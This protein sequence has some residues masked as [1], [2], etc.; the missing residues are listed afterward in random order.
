MIDNKNER[1]K[2][3]VEIS[4]ILEIISKEIY[5][6]SFALLREN[7]QNAYDAILMRKQKNGDD[8]DVGNGLIKIEISNNTI[9]VEDNGIGMTEDTL[10]EN[11]WKAGSSGKNTEFALSAGVIGTFGIGAMANFGVCRKLIVET[12][13]I[14][15]SITLYSEL[16]KGNISLSEDCILLNRTE[17]DRNPG[18]KITVELEPEYVISVEQAKSYIEQYVKYIPVMVMLNGSNMSQTDYRKLIFSDVEKLIPL[19]N[20]VINSGFYSADLNAMT[21]KSGDVIFEMTNIRFGNVMIQGEIVLKQGKEYVMGLRNY[22]GLAPIPVNQSY[23]LGGI[24]NLY[25]LQPTAGRE[26]LSRDSIE[27]VN[28][29]LQL[30]EEQITLMLS[31]TEYADKNAM[32]INY[33]YNKGKSDLAANVRVEVKPD[34]IEIRMKDIINNFAKFKIY[35]YIGRDNS[36][37]N[38]FSSE[39]KKLLLLSGTTS[40]QRIQVDYLRKLGVEEVPDQIRVLKIYDMKELATD[41]FSFLFRLKK[42]LEEDYFLKDIDILM[43]DIS[44]HIPYKI[45]NIKEKLTI[46]ISRNSQTIMPLLN[47][48]YTDF[49][50]FSSLIKD[51]VRI[52]LYPYILPFVPSSSKQGLDV[53]RKILLSKKE[54]FEIKY[55]EQGRLELEFQLEKYRNGEM[56]LE[57]VIESAKL[58]ST[59]HRQDVNSNQI[60]KLESEIPDIVENQLLQNMTEDINNQNRHIA[61]NAEYIPL[62]AISRD[63]IETNMKVLTL[64]N[65]FAQLNNFKMFLSLTEKV[66]DS[67]L[68]F[69]LQP[70]TTKI[71]WG[72]HRII[73]I[74]GHV[75]GKIT[76]YYD[77]DLDSSISNSATGGSAFQTTTI[78]TKNKIFVPVPE[79]LIPIFKV[80]QGSKRFFIR[81]DEVIE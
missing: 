47:C 48:Y 22:F 66:Y 19:G 27:H 41:E 79:P 46:Y 62:S 24:V 78:L 42:V 21:D 26:A 4:K 76:L 52:H 25:I 12:R 8:W 29:L 9:I 49:A 10:K 59:T 65:N 14:E 3:Q 72:S 73:Y 17:N 36:I 6:S 33:I 32:F 74:F 35:Y 51:F 38:S 11:F 45:E 5:D 44:H 55:N 34:N 50:V 64:D 39:G 16:D 71:I 1:F 63:Y 31:E 80:N 2:F 54:E 13:Y 28:K 20:K 56:S 81:Y 60:G 68:E 75:S 7:I 61:N 67:K 23:R 69:F 57:G 15:S 30:A 18:T 43:A 37:I 70:H 58:V 53:L 40:R 77:I